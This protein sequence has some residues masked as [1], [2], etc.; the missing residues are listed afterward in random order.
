[1]KMSVKAFLAIFLF[2]SFPSASYA[3]IVM[4]EQKRCPACADFKR[5]FGKKYRYKRVNV[6]SSAYRRYKKKLRSPVSFVPV[7][8]KFR[9]GKE[10]GRV[11]YRGKKYFPRD[12]RR[13]KRK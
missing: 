12:I 8:V 6:H 11:G 2:M 7:F 3:K 13:L 5:N 9:K 4:F 1:M 10:V